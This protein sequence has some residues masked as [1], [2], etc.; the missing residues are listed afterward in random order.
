MAAQLSQSTVNLAPFFLAAGLPEPQT[1]YQF[2]DRG[3]RFDYAWPAFLVA[4]EREGGDLQRG[5]SRHTSFKGYQADIIKY[6]TAALLGW[7][8]I[9]ATA[10]Q[11]QRG[12]HLVWVTDALLVHGWQPGGDS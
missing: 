6:N 2:S 11:V 8:I 1:E 5:Q 10:P 3:W 12:E 9:R 4:F 7:L